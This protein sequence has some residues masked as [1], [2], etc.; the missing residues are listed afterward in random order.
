MT[1]IASTQKKDLGILLR[2]ATRTAVVLYGDGAESREY[3]TVAAA[4]DKIE[5]AIIQTPSTGAVGLAIKSYLHRHIEGAADDG[6]AALGNGA[7]NWE[8]D[9]SILGD[10]IRFV[11]ELEPLAAGAFDSQPDEQ[12]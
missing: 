7:L 6:G 1:V 11:P 2:A 10:V 5:H 4:V 3:E 9:A 8:I 12:P